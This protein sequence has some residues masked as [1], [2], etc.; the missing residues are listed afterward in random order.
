MSRGEVCRG[1]TINLKDTPSVYQL[2]LRLVSYDNYTNMVG[3][4][5][6]ENDCVIP[7]SES[8]ELPFDVLGVDRLGSTSGISSKVK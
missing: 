2:V 4:V 3:L 6:L 7:G 5:K 8:L 1:K